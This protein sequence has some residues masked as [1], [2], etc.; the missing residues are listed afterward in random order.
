M[1]KLKLKKREH[2]LGREN[3]IAVNSFI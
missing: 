2:K 1:I 3:I